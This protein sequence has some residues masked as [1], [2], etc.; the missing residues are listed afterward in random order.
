MADRADSVKSQALTPRAELARLRR[1]QIEQDFDL[2]ERIME[3]V[4]KACGEKGYRKVSVQDVIDR[5]DG[6]R[7]QFYRHFASKADCYAAA[8]ETGVERLCARILGATKAA[9]D[10]PQ[11]LGGALDELARFVSERP[12]LARGL[13]VEVHVAGGSALEKRS[14][15]SSRLARALDIARREG[16]SPA[17]PPMTAAF[18][19]GAIEAAAI[20][21]LTA[22]E[23]KRFADAVPELAAIA[24]SAYFGDR[25][26]GEHGAHLPAA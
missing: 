6:N 20:S 16:A 15:V 2:R 18:V 14:E 11:R 26:P 25:V 13:L 24:T 17:A 19:V 7:A 4:L 12:Q 23:P 1:R 21:S 10:W 22:G 8:Y 3:A 5:Y 9:E